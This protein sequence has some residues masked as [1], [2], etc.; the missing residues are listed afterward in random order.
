DPVSILSK[1]LDEYDIIIWSTGDF[2]GDGYDDG[3]TQFDHYNYWTTP[4]TEG[5]DDYSDHVA[6]L[7][8]HLQH[9]GTLLLCGAY[10][11]RDLQNYPGNGVSQSEVDLGTV[12]GLK[13]DAQDRGGLDAS[14]HSDKTGKFTDGTDFD[15]G[16]IYASG[17]ISG[18]TGTSSDGTELA[19]I[20]IESDI[21][22][23]SLVKQNDSSFTYSLNS[24][25]LQGEGGE[26]TVLDEGFERSFPPSGWTQYYAYYNYK[27]KRSSFGSAHSGNYYAY[28]P[29]SSLGYYCDDW[30]VS[31]QIMIPANATLTFWEKNQYLPDWYEYHGIWISTGSGDPDDGDFIELAEY[32]A[33]AYS[34]TKRTLDLSTYAGS[35][36][37]IAFRYK[38]DYATRWK[39][40]DVKVTGTSS[41][42][43]SGNFAID[44]EIGD[45]RSIVLGFDLNDPAINDTSRERYLLNA[46]N[47]MAEAVGYPTKI[48]V[49]N[50]KST[51]WYDD[52]HVGSIQE[53]IER[54]MVGGT[55]YVNGTG[56]DNPYG[57]VNVIKSVS[58]IGKNVGYGCPVIK[59]SGEYAIRIPVDWAYVKNFTLTSS[60]TLNKGIYLDGSS[61]TS[62][63][64]CS[65]YNAQYGIY[66]HNSN[67]LSIRNNTLS[68]NTY[69]IY[70][71]HSIKSEIEDNN[72]YSGDYGVYAEQSYKNQ[73]KLNEIFNNTI[74]GIYFFSSENNYIQDSNEIYRN[75]YGIYLSYSGDNIIIGNTINDSTN[76]GICLSYSTDNQITLNEIRNNT[77]GINAEEY[78][79]GLN[80]FINEIYCNTEGIKV[81]DTNSV[82]IYDNNISRNQ[83]KNIILS[84]SNNNIISYNRLNH[85]N[86]GIYTTSSISNEIRDNTIWNS[87]YG[88]YAISSTDTKITDNTIYDATKAVVLE[89]SHPSGGNNNISRN[90]ICNSSYGIE[91]KSS[92]KKNM[93]LNNTIYG[94]SNYAIVL[95]SFSDDNEIKRNNISNVSYGIY[96]QS[97]RWGNLSHNKI[98]LTENAGISITSAADDNTLFNNTILNAST[99]VSLSS[100]CNSNTIKINT[101]KNI[102]GDGIYISLSYTTVVMNNTI[103]NNSNGIH[104]ISSGGRENN[105]INNTIYS[106][107]NHGIYLENSESTI[108][109]NEI[110]S[111]GGDGI[112]LYSSNDNSILTNELYS[113]NE[114]GIYLYSS[115]DN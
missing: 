3:S 88:L 10:A 98:F 114:N 65:I 80:I 75:G 113:N 92:S 62:I 84:S 91:L 78:S 66:A 85:S 112:Y 111:N 26:I 103:A 40:D 21:P 35:N 89:N 25:T 50:N 33:I 39:V 104:L 79:N 60:S 37:Y 46:V 49:D 93:I 30:L 12:L 44:A 15:Y 45:N 43:I 32:N 6:E 34:W 63:I 9:N 1:I 14:L 17:T 42:T 57:A 115:N 31:P 73:I 4:M 5:Y 83:E 108:T 23:Y 94:I 87:S 102:T 2:P 7:A 54:V 27:W 101:I 28:H 18:K 77:D 86:Y 16:P 105:I 100:G 24:S 69:N 51:S 96:I 76:S 68:G 82:T 47:W 70:L 38:G 41:G 110:Y 90:E 72:I 107:T 81:S 53:A 74:Y 95:S 59:T 11:V 8:T 106:N 55:I 61:S 22:L 58:I 19:N 56:I 71:D 29:D 99:G 109:G 48:Y 64:N 36:V 20:V 52:T 67:Y 13:Y 97:S